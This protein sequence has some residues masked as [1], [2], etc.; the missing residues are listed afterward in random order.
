[1]KKNIEKLLQYKRFKDMELWQK[2]NMGRFPVLV[3]YTS[4]DSRKHQLTEAN[5]GIEL[6]TLTKEDLE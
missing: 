3:F 4:K 2:R 6:L 5:P 1:M